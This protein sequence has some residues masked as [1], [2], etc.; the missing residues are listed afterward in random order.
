MISN[1]IDIENT[2]K[3]IKEKN[4]QL[5]FIAIP[6]TS[7]FD[8]YS[9]VFKVL[10]KIRIQDHAI[11]SKTLLQETPMHQA[12]LMNKKF[13]QKTTLFLNDTQLDA[14]QKCLTTDS[15]Y[16][17]HGPPG[18]GKTTT[19]TEL[20]AQLLGKGYKILVCAQSNAAVDNLLVK[21]AK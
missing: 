12:K 11:L 16:I 20:I 14:V 13:E 18:T 8:R 1:D 19:S 17:I 4:E 2:F 6:N 7:T 21:C 9:K 3:N 5:K 15:V 10:A